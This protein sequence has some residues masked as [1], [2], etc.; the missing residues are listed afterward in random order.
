[1][2]DSRDLGI[3]TNSQLNKIK[4]VIEYSTVNDDMHTM[5]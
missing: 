3:E 5:C 1:M 4:P 2:G